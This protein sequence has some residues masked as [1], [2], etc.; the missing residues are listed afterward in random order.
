MQAIPR[1]VRTT[2]LDGVLFLAPIIMIWLILSKAYNLA[3]RALV[4]FTVLI[5]DSLALRTTITA[6]LE[7]L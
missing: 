3:G 4:P 1:F 6:V 2:I 5:P 7:V